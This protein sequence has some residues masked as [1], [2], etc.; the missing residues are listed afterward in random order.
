MITRR[1]SISAHVARTALV[2]PAATYLIE[3][4]Y[5]LSLFIPCHEV[6]QIK[7]DFQMDVLAR[8][9][10]NV[11]LVAQLASILNTTKTHNKL[12]P[13]FSSQLFCITLYSSAWLSVM[14]HTL[15]V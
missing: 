5:Q 1:E 4:N 3:E 11:G 15:H 13:F 2:S 14:K 6:S 8:D 7:F 12:V 10:T 9:V